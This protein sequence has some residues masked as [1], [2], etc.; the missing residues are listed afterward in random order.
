MAS[1]KKIQICPPLP[2]LDLSTAGGEHVNYSTYDPIVAVASDDL[3]AGIQTTL[4]D[5]AVNDAIVTCVSCHRAHGSANDDLL[6]WDYADMDAGT[7]TV[8]VVG[9]GCF[10]CHSLKDG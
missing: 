5:T 9:S 1:V 8:G 2:D 7:T 10:K 4:Q 6:R 3:S